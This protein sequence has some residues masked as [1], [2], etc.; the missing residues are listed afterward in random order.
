MPTDDST[1]ATPYTGPDYGLG[2]DNALAHEIAQRDWRSEPRTHNTE[3]TGW[4]RAA[5]ADPTATSSSGLRREAPSTVTVS[6]LSPEM[7]APIIKQLSG[8]T[9]EQR[10]VR[11][12][13]LVMQ[14][15]RAASD[16]ARILTGLGSGATPLAKAKV[17]IAYRER[18]FERRID[19]WAQKLNEKTGS[20]AVIDPETGKAVID[21]ATGEPK[22]DP[23]YAMSDGQRA[24]GQAEMNELIR[25][26]A[27]LRGPEGDRE[28]DEALKATVALEKERRQQR[29]DLIEVERRAQEI[30]RNEDLDRRAAVRAKSLR[31]TVN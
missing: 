26:L 16:E 6:A 23:I 29:P 24:A 20:R 1:D 14:A 13:E 12:P 28:L 9:P 30:V 18:E 27:V 17:N 8:M 2:D 4:N 25:L 19:S 22:M 31:S 5:P 7:A 10:A 15:V 11:E 3:R 21:P